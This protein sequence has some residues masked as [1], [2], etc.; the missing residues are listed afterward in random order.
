MTDVVLP[1]ASGRA[2]AAEVAGLFPGLPTLF[3]SGYTENA[4]VHH[5]VIDTGVRFIEKPFTPDA[6]LAKIREAIDGG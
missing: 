3:M 6:L 5:G 2:L 1:G 4:I